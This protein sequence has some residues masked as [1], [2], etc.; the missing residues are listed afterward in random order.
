LFRNGKEVFAGK[1]SAVTASQTSSGGGIITLGTL[2]LGRELM[3][4]E[5]FLQIIVI[6]KLARAEKQVSDQ[7]IDF[8][9]VR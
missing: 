2:K 7:W 5:Y 3:A 6:D 8:E 1:E 4:G 9:I